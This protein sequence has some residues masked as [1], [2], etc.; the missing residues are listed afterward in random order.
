MR[1]DL[2]KFIALGLCCAVVATSSISAQKL[3]VMAKGK[4]NNVVAQSYS[5]MIKMHLANAWLDKAY[6]DTTNKNDK[7]WVRLDNSNEGEDAG[8]FGNT[9]TRF[10]IEGVNE[11]NLS[12]TIIIKEGEGYVGQY[13]YQEAGKKTVYLTAEDNEDTDHIYKI[14]GKWK[15][16]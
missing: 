2:K 5:G 10:W 12:S 13:V 9:L 4:G 11:N 14:S 1:R 3:G 7:F 15:E 16:E 8:K 6:R